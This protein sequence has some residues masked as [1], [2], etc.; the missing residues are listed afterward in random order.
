[1]AESILSRISGGGGVSGITLTELDPT[2]FSFVDTNYKTFNCP[3]A[4]A[5]EGTISRFL[6]KTDLGDIQIL[7][8]PQSD[9]YLS[10]ATT[11]RGQIVFGYS[12]PGT[13]TWTFTN[14]NNTPKLGTPQKAYS[15][16]I[17]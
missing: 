9:M 15:Y 11:S 17:D 12:S 14:S 13:E 8:E 3:M 7:L 2:I 10:Q 6:V 1:M 4:I 16:T 5:P